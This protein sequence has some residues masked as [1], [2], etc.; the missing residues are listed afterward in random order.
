MP[1]NERA[2]FVVD[3]KK[4]IGV[5]QRLSLTGGSAVLVKGPIPEGTVGEM[6]LNTVFGKV[7]AQIE[8]IH[9]GAD[10]KPHAQAFRFL[11]MDAVSEKRFAAAA[12]QMQQAGFSDVETKE[13]LGNLAAKGWDKLRE[14]VRQLG[15]RGSNKD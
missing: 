15:K 4:L 9:M 8:F 2:L 13:N 7:E 1:N 11:E 6:I 10:G 3:E 14:S 12:K 5:V